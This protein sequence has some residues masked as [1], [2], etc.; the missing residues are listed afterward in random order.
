M[1]KW[2]FK[3]MVDN[4]RGIKKEVAKDIEKLKKAMIL[5]EEVNSTFAEAFYDSLG[6]GNLATTNC[7]KGSVA[8]K[9]ST[10]IT[11]ISLIKS[12]LEKFNGNN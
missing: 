6:K 5:L 1:T 9:L 8:M 11:E 3:A 10:S 12:V 7:T 2:D 4:K